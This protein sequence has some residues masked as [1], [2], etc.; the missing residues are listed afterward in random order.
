[1]PRTTLVLGASPDPSRYAHKAVR[2]LRSHGHDV[3][4]I[5]RHTGIIDD[6]PILAAVPE[7]AVVDTVTLYLSPRNQLVWQDEILHLRPRRVIFNPGA[8]DAVFAQRLEG[9]GIEVVEGCT[10]V[11]LSTGGY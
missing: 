1:M 9:A 3:L 11:M 7:G 6:V 4:A 5:G 2:R 8:E 10:L